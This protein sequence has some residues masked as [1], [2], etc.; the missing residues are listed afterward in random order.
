ML[1]DVTIYITDSV[2]LQVL[3]AEEEPSRETVTFSGRRLPLRRVV[4]V[5]DVEEW[6]PEE[7]ILRVEEEG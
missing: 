5:G 1:K 2:P 3:E 6:I 7:M 4:T